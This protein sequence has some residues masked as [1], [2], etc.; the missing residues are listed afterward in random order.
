[1]QQMRQMGL[2]ILQELQQTFAS[3]RGLITTGVF[4]AVWVL[5]L[6]Y[7]VR[8]A[9][10][11]MVNPDIKPFFLSALE[12]FGLRT[13]STWPVKEL[14]VYW[15]FALYNFPLFVIMVSVDQMISDRARGGLRFILLRTDR[16]TLLLGRMLSHIFIHSILLLSTLVICSGLVLYNDVNNAVPL[17][18]TAPLVYVNL[19]LMVLP[20]IALMTFLSVV[21]KTIR[22]AL[23]W[24]FGILFFGAF[25]IAM[26][27]QYV[28]LAKFLVYTLP[29]V[30]LRI[31][32]NQ[33]PLDA[34]LL[35]YIPLL[36]FM[37]LLVTA[38]WIFREQEL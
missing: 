16:T 26:V 33:L 13:L 35:A 38:W 21:M 9:A 12:F 10:Y 8:Y 23:L 18:Q 32:A 5:I 1:M 11:A 6:L 30:Q 27:S 17:I 7:P 20:F 29:G 19:L 14:A 22:S 2:L 37:G 25:I 15:V 28:P 4:L 34:L 31:V 36:Q 24:T 3:K